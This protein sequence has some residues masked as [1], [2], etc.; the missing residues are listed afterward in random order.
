MCGAMALPGSQ[1]IVNPGFETGDF[2][3]WTATVSPS[4]AGE[5]TPWTVANTGGWF[6]SASPL[7]GTYSAFNGFDGDAG[8]VYE[9]YQ[10]VTI[11]PGSTALLA[12]NHRI[13]YDS[14]GIT[15][16]LPRS[17][18]ISVRDTSNSILQ[19]LLSQNITMTTPTV[20]TGWVNNVFDL[21][22]YAGSTVRIHFQDSIPES[23]TG[24]GNIQFDDI[25]L[26]VGQV[27]EP[28]ALSLAALGLAAIGLARRR[29]VC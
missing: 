10:D 29:R 23:F 20:D 28:G 14:L 16:S 27:P 5:L 13:V 2:T 7:S 9:L 3:G 12:T 8:V 26:D 25:S 4:G 17:F 24:P 11:A 21:S 15:S 1:I 19:V 6:G 22:A 18:E